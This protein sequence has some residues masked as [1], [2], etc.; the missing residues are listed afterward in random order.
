VEQ[1]LSEPA[2]GGNRS[3]KVLEDYLWEVAKTQSKLLPNIIERPAAMAQTFFARHSK[4]R[5]SVFETNHNTL[6]TPSS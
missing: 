6:G 4:Q 1:Y 3:V 5:Q 2:L